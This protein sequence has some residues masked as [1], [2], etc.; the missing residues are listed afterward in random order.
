MGTSF[1]NELVSYAPC[2][3]HVQTAFSHPMGTGSMTKRHCL[4]CLWT[5]ASSENSWCDGTTQTCVADCASKACVSNRTCR[6]WVVLQVC[7]EQ[8]NSTKFR[9]FSLV[10]PYAMLSFIVLDSSRLEAAGIDCH[11]AMLQYYVVF[12]HGWTT[13]YPMVLVPSLSHPT[14]YVGALVRRSNQLLCGVST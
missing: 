9:L 4:L 5:R 13:R 10:Q 7:V 2:T 1:W 6:C 11:S 3:V 8:R 14:S 12:T